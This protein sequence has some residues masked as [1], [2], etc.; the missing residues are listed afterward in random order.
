MQLNAASLPFAFAQMLSWS[1]RIDSFMS[2]ICSRMKS[3]LI[4]PLPDDAT[5]NSDVPWNMVRLTGS[6]DPL[7][8]RGTS[9]MNPS[10]CP[11]DDRQCV[12]MSFM[13]VPGARMLW[14]VCSASGGGVW[15]EKEV[16]LIAVRAGWPVYIALGWRVAKGFRSGFI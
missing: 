15:R 1:A 9:S 11:W 14:M 4:T 10:S 12:G 3:V 2:L 13:L 5:S 6:T 16:M 7:S 8:S